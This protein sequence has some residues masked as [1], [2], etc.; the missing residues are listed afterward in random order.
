M[1]TA[2]TGQLTSFIKV[3]NHEM[4]YSSFMT[5][6]AIEN[7]IQCFNQLLLY[8]NDTSNHKESWIDI[9]WEAVLVNQQS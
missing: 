6:F 1:D 3:S 7:K 8:E 5:A 2:V 4:E 9:N